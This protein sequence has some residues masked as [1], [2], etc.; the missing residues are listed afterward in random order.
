MTDLQSS[1]MRLIRSM[2]SVL[3]LTSAQLSK[4]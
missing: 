4:L 1:D 3:P 2:M